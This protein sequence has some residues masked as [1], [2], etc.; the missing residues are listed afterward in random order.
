MAQV[1]V[2]TGT[3]A[4]GIAT[5]AANGDEAGGQDGAFGLEFSLAGLEGAADQGGVFGYFHE[6]LVELGVLR[7]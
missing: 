2:A 5:S 1:F 3:A 4:I 7:D 6:F